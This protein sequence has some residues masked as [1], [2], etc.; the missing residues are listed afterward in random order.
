MPFPKQPTQIEADRQAKAPY[1]FVPLPDRIVK[2]TADIL[3]DQD[4]YW[5]TP[6]PDMP[7]GRLSGEIVCQLTTESPV[8]TRAA[9]TA[10]Q[11]AQGTKA[12]DVP[13]FFYVLSED[14]PVIPGSSLRGLIRGMVEIVSYG[15]VGP[16][17]DRRL[18]Y[19]AVGDTT[20]HGARYRDRLMRD[21]GERDRRKHYTPLMR[22]GYM[23]KENGEWFIEPAKEI[24]GAT[25][26]HCSID[27]KGLATL[28]KAGHLKNTYEVY[29]RVGPY[30]YQNVRGGFLRIK[31]APV[32]EWSD[33]PKPGLRAGIILAKSGPVNSKRT[34]AVIYEREPEAQ[35]L[36]VSDSLLDMYRDQVTP[37]QEAILGSKDGV[38]RDGQPI[39]YL[40]DDAGRLSF[41][42]HC[43]MLRLPY[44]AR[45][46]DLVPEELRREEDLDLAEAIFGYTKSTGRGKA[47]AY[48]GRVFF[49]DAKLIEGQSDLWLAP[50]RVVE[51]KILAG[52]KPTTFQ[53]YLVQTRPN[54]KPAGQTRD[55]RAKFVVELSDYAAPTPGETVIRG[56]KL[57]WHKG[58]STL[59]DIR[60]TQPLEARSKPGQEDKKD[61]Q[62]THIQPVRAGV[63]FEFRIRFENL[64]RPELGALLWVLRVAAHPDYRLKLGMGKPLGMGAVKIDAQLRLIDRATRYAALLDEDG[65]EEGLVAETS[66]ATAVAEMDKAVAEF[67][68]FM[69]KA[70]RHPTARRLADVDR[71]RELLAMLS[72]P[73][74]D[75]AQTRYLEIERIEG[76]RRINEYRPRPVLPTPQVVAMSAP[77]K[78]DVGGQNPTGERHPHPTPPVDESARPLPPGYR[79][80]RVQEFGASYGFIQPEGGGKRVFVHRNQLAGGL[81][82]LEPG[83]IVTYTVGPGMKGEEAKDVKVVG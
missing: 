59:D 6:T 23:K 70:L 25:Y 64:L 54:K 34:E 40:L 15:K 8:Y 28:S 39:F 80:G 33:K 48:A 43:R 71:I 56:H 72:W 41:F 31:Y 77:S 19:R 27:E 63:R 46:C 57:Y 30:D 74:P 45:L 29:I 68:R 22:G 58:A 61:T 51:P 66:D 69:L 52:P 73:G 78:R 67:E 32:L 42:G 36:E 21:D 82:R 37:G 55:G 50:G 62:H 60:E 1:N 5:P 76:G 17:S 4:R 13:A 49:S 35:R 81:R 18:V 2:F 79:R 3:P 20:S 65:W 75:P 38:L 44:L 16:V 14:Q 11:Y 53:H 83:Q 9:V 47:R 12:K 24:D 10:E 7:A 26:A